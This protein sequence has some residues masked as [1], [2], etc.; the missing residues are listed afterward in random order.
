[1]TEDEIIKGLQCCQD[2]TRAGRWGNGCIAC[3]Y[4]E[5]KKPDDIYET[6]REKLLIDAEES[7]RRQQNDR[8]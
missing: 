1:M 8:R 4:R 5:H 2:M 6:C 7:L 3:P